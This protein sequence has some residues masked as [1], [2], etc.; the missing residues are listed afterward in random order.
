MR[1]HHIFAI[2]LGAAAIAGMTPVAWI[3][4]AAFSW[5]WLPTWLPFER[6]LVVFLSMLVAATTSLLLAG[7]PAA[8]FERI[9]GADPDGRRA[10]WIWAASA[11]ALAS[12]LVALTLRWSAAA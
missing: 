12:G 4:V 10:L 1:P 9:G 2:A 11:C 6:G 8:L 3:V 5:I 7:I